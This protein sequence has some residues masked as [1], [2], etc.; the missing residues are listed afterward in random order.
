MAEREIDALFAMVDAVE[1]EAEAQ[2]RC[3][4]RDDLVDALRVPERVDGRPA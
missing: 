4:A 1:T 3:D 2:T